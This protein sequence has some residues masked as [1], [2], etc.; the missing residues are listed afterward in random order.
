MYHRKLANTP[1]AL[2]L[3]N[4]LFLFISEEGGAP[5]KMAQD[6]IYQNRALQSAIFIRFRRMG[7]LC[8]S[9]SLFRCAC[10]Q[11]P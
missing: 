8:R 10:T 3:R 6:V 9:F 7:L 11:I 5:D 2:I 4:N 1:M